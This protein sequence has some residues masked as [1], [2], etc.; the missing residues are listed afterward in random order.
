M[1]IRIRLMKWSE[2]SWCVQFVIICRF[3]Y[4]IYIP[5]KMYETNTVHELNKSGIWDIYLL[6]LVG[7][8]RRERG[9]Q[10]LVGGRDIVGYRSGA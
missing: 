9:E 7:W 2:G 5:I 3:L 1:I 6:Y 10:S 8:E 4:N